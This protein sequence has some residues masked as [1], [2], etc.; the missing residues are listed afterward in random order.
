MDKLHHD[1]DEVVNDASRWLEDLA[2]VTI[3]VHADDAS[4]LEVLEDSDLIV[5][6]KDGV[7]VSAEELFLE[8]LDCNVLFGSNHFAKVNLGGVA[9]S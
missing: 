8:D 6:R 4:V 2:C 9:F 3:L 5:D 1:E 7:L